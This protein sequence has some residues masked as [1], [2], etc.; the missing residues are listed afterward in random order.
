MNKDNTTLNED[1]AIELI[2]YILSSAQG[3]M[4]EPPE[5]AVLRMVSIADRMAA[6]WAPKTEGELYDFLADL[7]QRM[8]VESANTQGDDL[9]SFKQY[10]GEK[11]T[12]LA[13]IVKDRNYTAKNDDA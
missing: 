8:P 10:L 9:E 3:L 6:M 12:E 1:E 5:Y 13:H 11:V 2:A 7:S 4:K